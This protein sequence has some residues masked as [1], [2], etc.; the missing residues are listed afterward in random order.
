MIVRNHA[1]AHGVISRSDSVGLRAPPRLYGIF[2]H[3]TMDFT[4]VAI[5]MARPDLAISHVSWRLTGDSRTS[6]ARTGLL[7][8][9]LV[10]TAGQWQI[11]AAQNTEIHRT[12]H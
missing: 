12:V 4:S 5:R 6:L 3:S 10:P 8:F 1:F 11:E 9:V 7:T 2:R